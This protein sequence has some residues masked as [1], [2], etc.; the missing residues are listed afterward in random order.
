MSWITDTWISFSDFD[1]FRFPAS[2]T[3]SFDT[4]IESESIKYL[5]KLL[6]IELYTLFFD[7][8]DNSLNSVRFSSLRDGVIFDKQN[9]DKWEFEGLKEMC[10]LFAM[11]YVLENQ[12]NYTNTGIVEDAGNN[13]DN[14][15]PVISQQNAD[16][17]YEQA[18]T[19]YYNTALYLNENI[20]DFPEWRYA[21]I[22]EKNIIRY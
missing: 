10:Q 1:K 4:I 8:F 9:G 16:D 21:D 13:E 7:N 20:A 14:V 2:A 12:Y 6:G 17:I 19:K 3:D 22:E 15:S 11:Y 18:R 5:K